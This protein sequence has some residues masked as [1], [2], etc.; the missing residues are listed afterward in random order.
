MRSS[1]FVPQSYDP[2]SGWAYGFP[3]A[4]PVGLETTQANIRAQ[5]KADGY[6]ARDLDFA[7]KHT[8]F[9][10][11]EMTYEEWLQAVNA[12]VEKHYGISLDL[13]PDWLSRDAYDDGL[14]VQEGAILCAEQTGLYE[15]LVDE[16]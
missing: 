14:S 7:V 9:L 6:P 13:L 2:P 16:A 12:Q 3:K 4:W 5:L 8:R 10:G 11:R 1:R 15:S